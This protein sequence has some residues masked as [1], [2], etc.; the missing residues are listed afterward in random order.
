MGRKSARIGSLDSKPRN[1][2]AGWQVK[3]AVDLLLLILLY[4]PAGRQA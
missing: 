3:S 4:L 2:P 1:Q